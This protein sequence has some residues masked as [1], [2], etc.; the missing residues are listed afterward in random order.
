MNSS[1]ITLNVALSST[2]ISLKDSLVDLTNIPKNEQRLIYK[3]RKLVHERT[4]DSYQTV[5]EPVLNA[6]TMCGEGGHDMASNPYMALT[7]M[8]WAAQDQPEG[9]GATNITE[10][11]ERLSNLALHPRNATPGAGIRADQAAS[12]VP[13]AGEVLPDL[14][15]LAGLGLSELEMMRDL[16]E[17][18]DPTILQQLVHNARIQEMHQY[19]SNPTYMNQMTFP[20]QYFP[21][22]FSV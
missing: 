18:L 6:T 4:L 12:A 5:Q 16:V 13:G 11:R 10:L 17:P 20:C 9:R 14:D 2:V 3:G 15:C 1:T 22:V 8:N 19:L 7:G 21:S